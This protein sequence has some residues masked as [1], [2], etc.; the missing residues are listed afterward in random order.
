[1]AKVK[2]EKPGTMLVTIA[3]KKSRKV[4]KVPLQPLL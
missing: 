2:A 3:T 1:M 4:W